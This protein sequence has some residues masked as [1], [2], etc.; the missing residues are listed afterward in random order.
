M[1]LLVAASLA[2]LVVLV[3]GSGGTLGAGPVQTALVLGFFG[4]T[5]LSAA[6]RLERG[7]AWLGWVGILASLAAFVYW[8]LLV[9]EVFPVEGFDQIKPGLS[10]GLAATTIAYASLLLLARGP[11]RSVNAVIWVT[12]LLLV[13]L[14][15]T[16][17]GLILT[18]AE[19]PDPLERALGAVAILILLGTLLA[20]VLRA[21]F[22]VGAAGDGG[23]D[24]RDRG[25]RHRARGAGRRSE[26]KGV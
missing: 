22:R 14:A 7:A 24:S 2:A 20:P 9:W 5:G 4:L 10:L 3:L 18:D 16:V 21:F 26:V 1:V 19:P 23:S 6:V 15:A 25:G 13:V 12:E 11:Y 17:I 8:E